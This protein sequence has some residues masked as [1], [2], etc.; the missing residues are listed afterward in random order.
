MRRAFE[1]FHK[2]LGK[3]HGIFA[4]MLQPCRSGLGKINEF[5]CVGSLGKEVHMSDCSVRLYFE[6]LHFLLVDG[7]AHARAEQTRR[8]V[9]E[10]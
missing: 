5:E 10:S 2:K 9:P 4:V 1:G 6:V 7:V 8:S 3:V